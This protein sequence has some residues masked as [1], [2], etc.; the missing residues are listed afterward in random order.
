M[1]DT[2]VQCEVSQ[3]IRAGA[4][5]VEDGNHGESRPRPGEFTDEGVAYIRAADMSTG[6]V[7][8][9]GAQKVSSIALARITKGIGRPG[10]SI[11]SHKGTVG[12][13]ALV[14]LDAPPFVC[15]PQTTLWRSLDNQVIHPG[16]LYQF[17]RSPGFQSQLARLKN[18]TDMAPYVS[19]TQQRAMTIALP[20]LNVQ[21]AIAEVLGALDDKIAAN[22]R[23]V[24][25]AESLAVACV[26]ALHRWT[27][28]GSLVTHHRT[29]V[30]PESLADP[31][32]EHFSLPSFDSGKHPELAAPSS[33]KSGKFAIEQPS[34]LISK[35][36]P[37]IPRIWLTPA[38]TGIPQLASTEFLVLAP[39][40][41][42]P[43]VL[44]A[45]AMQPSFSAALEGKVAG[46]SGS[47]QRVKPSDM[48]DTPI[49]DPAGLT[50]K[51]RSE[52]VALCASAQSS[53]A[54]NINLAAIRVALLPALMSGR[55]HVKEAEK[56]VSDAV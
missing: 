24:S 42:E 47:H 43:A 3:L 9:T 13:V 31:V 1:A 53:R 39:R 35:L 55:L 11:L 34:V 45:L 40:A 12:K 14:P 26:S 49:G 10:D 7:S 28:L 15:S 5:R 25:A 8:F 6:I 27:T 37:R 19:L 54:E 30:S 22:T 51:D 21:R 33:I 36:N 32:V 44:W 48:L 16:Y 29:M 20:P 23:V 46:T 17:L 52:I 4:L 50:E 2:F 18:N 56:V 41:L 38:S